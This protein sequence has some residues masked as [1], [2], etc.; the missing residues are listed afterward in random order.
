MSLKKYCILLFSLLGWSCISFC[1]ES[2]I[3]EDAPDTSIFFH[4]GPITVPLTHTATKDSKGNPIMV[5]PL[6]PTVIK[7]FLK[8][9]GNICFSST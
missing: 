7:G 2:E 8:Y 9:I 6:Q 3:V 1:Q 4:W 5:Q